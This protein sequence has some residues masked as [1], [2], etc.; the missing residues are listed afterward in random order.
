V[1]RIGAG[2]PSG[3]SERLDLNVIKGQPWSTTTTRMM[4]IGR[5]L[6]GEPGLEPAKAAYGKRSYVRISA[7]VYA[8]GGA[9]LGVAWPGIVQK[10]S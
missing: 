7:A 10:S 3:L 8:K 9:K 2:R 6:A 1:Y 4:L 5:L